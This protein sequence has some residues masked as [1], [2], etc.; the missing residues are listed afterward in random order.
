MKTFRLAL[1]VL[2]FAGLA[3]ARPVVIEESARITMP[4]ASWEHFGRFGVAIDGDYALISGDR[5][6]ADP[7]A[8]SGVREEGV[9]FLFRRSG[10]TWNY[11]GRLGPVSTITQWNQPGLAMKDGV[12]VTWIGIT[13]IF[14]LNGGMWTRT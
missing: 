13:R 2:A 1:F 4:E 5:V 10:S 8:P 6:V 12:A 14:E 7:S 9:V 11:Q 3:Q